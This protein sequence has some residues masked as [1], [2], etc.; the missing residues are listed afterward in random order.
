MYSCIYN[1]TYACIHSLIICISVSNCV[2]WSRSKGYWAPGMAVTSQPIR[3][4]L[5]MC[6]DEYSYSMHVFRG[7]ICLHA[8]VYYMYVCMFLIV[9]VLTLAHTQ[10][11]YVSILLCI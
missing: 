11:L 3:P 10:S 7:C 8:C 5:G 4:L 6:I 1:S 9:Y 2:D